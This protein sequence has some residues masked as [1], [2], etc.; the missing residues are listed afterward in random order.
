MSGESL[1][2]GS[3]VHLFGDVRI[4]QLIGELIEGRGSGRI[5]QGGPAHNR[6]NL[7]GN[8]LV[9]SGNFEDERAS[10]RFSVHFDD[11]PAS[12]D[13]VAVRVRGFAPAILFSGRCRIGANFLKQSWQCLAPFPESLAELCCPR[14][15]R[16][17]GRP[18][19]E[20]LLKSI[21]VEQAA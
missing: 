21:L 11:F 10:L 2:D 12:L 9:Q 5:A 14:P 15:Y 20:S 1:L 16:Q 7:Q 6:P 17:T 13:H 19:I 8:L 3:F 4:I 18:S